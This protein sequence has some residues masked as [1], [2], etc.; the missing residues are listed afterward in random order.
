MVTNWATS[1]SHNKNRGFRRFLVLSYH[2]VFF[3]CP[4]ICQFS[5][6]SLFRKKRVQKLG[7]SNICV[8]SSF[9]ENYLF[10]GLLKHYKNRGF[11]NFLCFL[12]LKEKEKARKNDNWNLWIWF[13]CPKMA[14]SWRTS[15]LCCWNPYFYS[16]CWVC[17]LWAKV[18]EKGNFENTPKKEKMTD[19]W[20]A[21]FL[22]FLYFLLLLFFLGFFLFFV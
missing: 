18:S 8:L 4:V 10:L 21:L 13:L 9:F 12:L 6:N 5:K 15:A 3:L 22:I 14:V 1:F 7:F 20:K 19:N 17:A 2:F 16:V 11:S